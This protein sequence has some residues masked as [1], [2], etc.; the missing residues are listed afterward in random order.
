MLRKKIAFKI[1]VILG[2]TLGIGLTLLVGS[3]IYLQTKASKQLELHS[4]RNLAAVI[5]KDIDEYMMKDASAE[6]MKY[7]KEAKQRK[8]VSDLAIFGENAKEIGIQNSPE[9][10]TIAKALKSGSTIEFTTTDNGIKTLNMA[11]PMPNEEGCKQCHDKESKFL[12]GI[13]IKTSLQEGHELSRKTSLTLLVLSL[14]FFLILLGTLYF[15]L[16]KT[17]INPIIECSSK[18]DELGRGEG[19]LTQVIP[20]TSEDELGNLAVGINSLISKI[21]GI[22][23]Q[24]SYNAGALSTAADRLLTNSVKMSAGINEAV[25]QTDMVATASEE[26]A[27]TSTDIARNCVGAAAESTRASNSSATG[28]KVVEATVGVMARI[29]D[30]VRE[31]AGTI[32][33]LGSR[34]DQIGEIIGTIE[35]IADQTNLLALNA[36]IEAARAGEQGRGFA[37]VADEVRALA[38]RTTRATR[39]IG[40]M[41]KVIQNETKSAVVSMEEGVREVEL[42]TTE[43]AKSGKALQDIMDEIGAVVMQVNQ[44]ATAAEEQTA[45]TSEISSNIHQIT[46]VVQE[47][48]RGA[49]ESSG[50][51]NELAALANDLKRLVGQFKL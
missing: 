4:T 36:A 6:V 9:N 8:F 11:V 24:I 32:E 20:V 34:S 43:T 1:L 3:S 21:H 12:G 44:I 40:E 23:S 10:E 50:S 13:L 15:F 27:A 51:A 45:T 49:Q 26:M 17:I 31:S 22:I 18:V 30:K 16:K 42:G 5:I 14:S 19:D 39:E 37:V 47:A 41:I 25:A 48:A 28:A 35:D 2:F 33:S 7:I 29:A 46:A 38:E